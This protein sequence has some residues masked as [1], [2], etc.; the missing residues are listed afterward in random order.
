M[1]FDTV[2]GLCPPT[3]GTSKLSSSETIEAIAHPNFFLSFSASE[4]GVL[5]P[6]A[7]SPVTWL[8]PSE[9]TVVYFIVPPWNIAI[10]VVPPPMS[11]IT[12]PSS[13]SS[14]FRTA[15]LLAI[16]WSAISTTSS[17]ALF[18][19]LIMFWADVTAAVTMWTFTS[20]LIPFMPSGSCM[21]SWSSMMYS[22]GMTCMTSLSGGIATA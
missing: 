19:H 15:S 17:P 13:R 3:P 8:P 20:S 6:T 9:M 21:P 18:A 7:I 4:V 5:S 22:C 1:C 16:C 10:S 11:I 12:T 14:L 2:L